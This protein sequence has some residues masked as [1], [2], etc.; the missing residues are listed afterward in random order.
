MRGQVSAIDV[1]VSCLVMVE[2]LVIV[3]SEIAFSMNNQPMMLQRYAEYLTIYDKGEAR[4]LKSG[5]TLVLEDS[6]RKDNK[7]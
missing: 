7:E 3:F 4:T 6:S 1:G 2:I 5:V